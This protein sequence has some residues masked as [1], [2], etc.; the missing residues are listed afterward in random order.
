MEYGKRL[1]REG[2][3]RTPKGI[4][5][6]RQKVI[7]THNPS[8]TDQKPRKESNLGVTVRPRA[9]RAHQT[10]NKI[11]LNHTL[12][13]NHRP[14]SLRWIKSLLYYKNGQEEYSK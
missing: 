8:E 10:H 3:L 5:G 7:V 4:K 6:T 13:H 11:I 1:N 12:R 14:T 2:S 9:R